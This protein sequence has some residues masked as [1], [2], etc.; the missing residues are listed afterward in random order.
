MHKRALASVVL[1]VLVVAATVGILIARQ[2]DPVVPPVQ[3]PTVADPPGTLLVQLRDPRLLAVGS[4]LMGVREDERLDQLWWTTQWWIDQIGVQEVSAAEL[5]RQPV[6]AVMQTVQNQVGVPVDDAW[7]LDRLAFAGLVDAVGGV[8]IAVASPTVYLTEAGTPALIPEGVQTL[9][10]AQAADFVADTSLVDESVRSRRFQSVWDQILRRFPTDVD[11][12]RTLVVSLG[13]LSKATMPTEELAVY[14]ADA[15]D[16]RIRGAYRQARVRLDERN[17]V[18]VRPPQGVREA[19]A[20]DPIVTAARIADLFDGYPALDE[21]V[22]RIQA[23]TVRD[24]A[25]EQIRADLVAQS[26]A[27][28]WGGRALTTAT[29]V[30]VA[31]DVPADEVA[32]LD[33]AVGVPSATGDVAMA[34]ARV[35]VA[36]DQESPVGS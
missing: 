10:G 15:H 30:T 26:W 25:V 19:Y 22:A 35:A 23:V 36:A 4:V 17:A 1:L 32:A 27:S 28:A 16:L 31:P 7:V 8:R 18:R 3:S 14:L 21:P 34:Q 11:K 6:P 24:D 9:T 29:T 12:A 33:E 2:Q 5:G 20:M 13:A